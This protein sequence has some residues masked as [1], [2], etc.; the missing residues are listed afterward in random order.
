M[1]AIILISF[2]ILMILGAPIAV[3]MGL[4]SVL[5]VVISGE[6]N[7]IAIAQRTFEGV[8]SFALLA[9]PLFTLSG[10][11][12]GTGGI[13]RRLIHFSYALVGHFRGGLAH[14]NVV[15][16]MI[17]AGM[18][19]SAA[20]DTAYESGLLMP[21]M[22]KKGYSKEF[23]VAVTA[24]SSTI[25]IIIP[26]SIPM[27]IMAGMVGISTGKV[28][29]GG[30]LPG[31]LCGIG[32]LVVNYFY[33][34]R[35]NVPKEESRFNLKDLYIAFKESFFALLMLPVI[36]VSIFSGIVSPTEAGLVAVVYALVVGGLVYKE[37]NLAGIRDA[38]VETAKTSAKVFFIIGAAN[39]FGKLLTA[40]GLHVTLTS[41]LTGV[42]TSPTVL[43]LLI[44]AIML[45]LGTFMESISMITLMM[46]VLYPI[47]VSY[48][49]D[50]IVMS[51][52]IV[53][54]V[55][56]GLVTP[57]QGMCLFIAADFL[58]VKIWDATKELLPYILV[59]IVII[60]LCLVFPQLITWPASL[61]Q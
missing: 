40:D 57:P 37:L 32:Q 18:S 30:I 3:A 35:E 59:M 16:S 50:P 53:I 45:F 55:A 24:I 12:M 17:F 48:G 42:T 5:G 23:T 51:V 28:F 61:I 49:I 6:A 29:L 15:Q 43:L 26:P 38:L 58:K 9:V 2:A 8:N 44:M 13:G 34:V 60:I 39:L 4:S 27:V 36:M 1:T 47:A 19:G 41:W 52:M 46:P 11:L 25:G 31:I 10:L 7:F 33:A 21:E 20:A 22:V 56:V 14:V 54:C